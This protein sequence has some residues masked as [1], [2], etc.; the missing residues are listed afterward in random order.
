MNRQQDESLIDNNQ[1]QSV[2]RKALNETKN[3]L[4]RYKIYE[5]KSE[6]WTGVTVGDFNRNAH[7]GRIYLNP[8]NT[9][10]VNV[11]NDIV[12]LLT[13]NGNEFQIKMP[14]IMERSSYNRSDKVVLYF[15]LENALS[16][17]DLL[18]QYLEQNNE[19]M[20]KNV[21]IFTKKLET[22][23][24]KVLNGVSFA[25][26]PINKQVS[27][28]RQ[29]SNILA[30]TYA[31]NITQGNFLAKDSEVVDTFSGLCKNFG[32]DPH[33]PYKNINSQFTMF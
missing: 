3:Y 11:Y 30:G 26:N 32:V 5:E 7:H 4:N 16:I 10:M 6:Y 8:K 28:N 29:I 18:V 31:K 24:G 22:V 1:F 20:N 33:K 14:K 25:E 21:P 12:K 13:L 9:E 2:S 15:E 19:K 23:D 17:K 27:Y